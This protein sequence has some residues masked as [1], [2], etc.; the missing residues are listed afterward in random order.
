MHIL[1]LFGLGGARRMAADHWTQGTVTESKTCWWHKVNTKPARKHAL[2]G[3][4]F[5][6]IIAFQYTVDGKTY[7]G[8]R[9][10][11]PRYAAGFDTSPKP[12]DGIRVWYDPGR[13]ER[14][15]VQV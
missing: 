5:P 9:Y 6:H 13:P 12:G 14:Y 4:V 15:A 2:D 10:V 3:A 11:P 1:L 8:K 7:Q